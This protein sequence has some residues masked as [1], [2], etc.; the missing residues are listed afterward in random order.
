[1]S[2][3]PALLIATA[4]GIIVTRV[5]SDENRPL[6][7][8]IGR[9]LGRFPRALAVAAVLLFVLSIVPGL[10]GLP[11]GAAA[12][13]VGGLS[14]FAGRFVEAT[15]TTTATA[16]GIGVPAISRLELHL[17]ESLHERVLV[18]RARFSGELRRMREEIAADL[19]VALPP[20]RLRVRDSGPTKFKVCIDEVP[21]FEG[22][23]TGDES[24]EQIT[25]DSTV[26]VRRHAAAFVDLQSTQSMIETLREEAPALVSATVPDVVS[27]KQLCDVLR[28]LVEEDVSIRNLARILGLMAELGDGPH[29]TGLLVDVVREGLAAYITHRFADGGRGLRYFEIDRELEEMVVGASRRSGTRPYVALQ[30]ELAR[31]IVDGIRDQTRA[32]KGR[33]VL[34]TEQSARVYLHTLIKHDLPDHVVLARQELAPGFDAERVGWISI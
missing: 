13:V 18:Q 23:A 15:H 9:Q 24:L 6:G 4:A 30:P 7:E 8:E 5:A 25:R 28:F 22:I 17:S 11:F 21:V 27:P 32:A 29:D 12:I 10:P 2:Q 33:A 14:L 34:M 19:G 26:V 20:V 3:I 31:E 1:M 16:P